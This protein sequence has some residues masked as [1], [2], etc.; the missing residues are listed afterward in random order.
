[1]VCPKNRF[2]GVF[3]LSDFDIIFQSRFSMPYNRARNVNNMSFFRIFNGDFKT[4]FILKIGL[5][6]TELEPPKV[7]E[8][9]KISPFDVVFQ[10]SAEL[11]GS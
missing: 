9:M 5:K 6:L 4:S 1:M 10:L 2:L 3:L 11:C 7:S 8:T